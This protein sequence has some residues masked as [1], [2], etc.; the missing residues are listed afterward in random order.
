MPYLSLSQ[1]SAT[2]GTNIFWHHCQGKRHEVFFPRRTIRSYPNLDGEQD[3][4]QLHETVY[5]S[6]SNSSVVILAPKEKEKALKFLQL[7]HPLQ[8]NKLPEKTQILS[9]LQQCQ[10]LKNY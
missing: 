2:L 5:F 9:M 3:F 4:G 1:S 8:R 10:I 7:P 6:P